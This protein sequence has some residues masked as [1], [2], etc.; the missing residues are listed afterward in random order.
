MSLPA[1]VDRDRLASEAVDYLAD[2][3]EEIGIM[4][5]VIDEYSRNI[6]IDLFNEDEDAEVEATKAINN[7]HMLMDICERGMDSVMK[8]HSDGTIKYREI[9]GMAIN[10]YS[11]VYRLSENIT[12]TFV[13]YDITKDPLSYDSNVFDDRTIKEYVDEIRFMF[14]GMIQ[15]YL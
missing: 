15:D 7:A 2:V 8:Y 10:T 12:N 3:I 13:M 1:N 14:K 6:Y 4:E 5:D 9:V 11:A